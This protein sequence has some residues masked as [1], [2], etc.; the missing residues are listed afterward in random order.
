A[1][2]DFNA[3]TPK[4]LGADRD[5]L[6]KI[7]RQQYGIQPVQVFTDIPER[8]YEIDD[9]G[10]IAALNSMRELALAI[11]EK[12]HQAPAADAR[13]A[14]QAAALEEVQVAETAADLEAVDALVKH[15]NDYGNYYRT[16]IFQQMPWSDEFENLLKLF[17]PLIGRQVLGFSGSAVGLPV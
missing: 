11:Q 8:T 7:L 5:A 17:Y 4:L 12:K 1:V 14:N 10:V 13:A 3:L 16:A 15:L 2:T 6:Y 9:A